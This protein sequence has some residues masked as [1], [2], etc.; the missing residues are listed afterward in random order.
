MVR[1][2]WYRHV[3]TPHRVI[4]EFGIP[5]PTIRSHIG[6]SPLPVES[7]SPTQGCER[8][9]ARHMRTGTTPLYYPVCTDYVT[10]RV[11][12]R[13]AYAKIVSPNH[14][15]RSFRFTFTP[16]LCQNVPALSGPYALVRIAACVSSCRYPA[17]KGSSYKADIAETGLQWSWHDADLPGR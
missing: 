16:K 13:T 11:K 4:H 8:H 2:V 7:T 17:F 5:L 14:L 9:L 15:F 12:R 6:C 10:V 3:T 1:N